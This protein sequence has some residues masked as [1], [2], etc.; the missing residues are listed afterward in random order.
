MLDLLTV[1]FVKTKDHEIDFYNA[2]ECGILHVT[3]Q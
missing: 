3:L 1:H 2:I